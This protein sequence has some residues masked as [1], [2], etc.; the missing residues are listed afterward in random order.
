MSADL[1]EFSSHLLPAFLSGALLL[2]LEQQYGRRDVGPGTMCRLASHVRATPSA[3]E[4]PRLDRR[5]DV[6]AVGLKAP[7]A[8]RV[9]C[10][11]PPMRATTPLCLTPVSPHTHHAAQE[12]LCPL[13]H[14]GFAQAVLHTDCGPLTIDEALHG[15][16]C[17]VRVANKGPGAAIVGCFPITAARMEGEGRLVGAPGAY[18]LPAARA[19]PLE[20]H[21]LGA[22][23][24]PAGADGAAPLRH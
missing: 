15:C 8:L 24:C 10:F 21:M 14:C 22:P 6:G 18:Q 9:L 16:V 20:P 7:H 11:G 19:R 1:I 4:A 12:P 3:A 5:S 13:P 2:Q 17:G 23:L